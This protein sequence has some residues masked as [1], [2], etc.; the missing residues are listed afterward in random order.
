M[1]RARPLEHASEGAYDLSLIV[2]DWKLLMKVSVVQQPPVYLNLEATMSRAIE[3]IAAEAATGSAMIVFPEAW[4]PGYPVFVWRLRPGA[5]MEKTD[6]LY[7]ILLANSI[8]RTKGGLAPL[9]RAAKE[10]GIVVVAAY[11]GGSVNLDSG[12]SGVSA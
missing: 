8:D 6:E 2:A 9:Q 10:H 5:D 11:R 1:R 7:A 4:F 3:I 12:L